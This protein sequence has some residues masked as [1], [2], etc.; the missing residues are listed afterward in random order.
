M[1]RTITEIA[2]HD[3]SMAVPALGPGGQPFVYVPTTFDRRCA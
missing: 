2:A 3:S 1:A